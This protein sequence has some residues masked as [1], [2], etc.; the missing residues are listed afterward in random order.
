M[1]TAGEGRPANSKEHASQM[2]VRDASSGS[3]KS[4]FEALEPFYGSNIDQPLSRTYYSPL[5][6]GQRKALS[7]KLGLENS[8]VARSID[9]F[10]D[11]WLELVDLIASFLATNAG[12]SDEKTP[13]GRRFAAANVLLSATFLL[14][15]FVLGIFLRAFLGRILG[16]IF[17]ILIVGAWIT[18]NKSFE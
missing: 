4:Q 17:C 14:F 1:S 11:I 18:S 2:T 15:I 10:M 7:A 16:Y 3:F 8:F 9:T 12:M 5:L 6:P 13:K